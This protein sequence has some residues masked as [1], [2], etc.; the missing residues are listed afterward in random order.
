MMEDGK[1]GVEDQDVE[2]VTGDYEEDQN[3]WTWPCQCRGDHYSENG[4]GDELDNH[5]SDTTI[6]MGIVGVAASSGTLVP[7]ELEREK[8]VR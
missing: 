6:G 3:R 7:G 8:V 5:L 4:E 1:P 2:D